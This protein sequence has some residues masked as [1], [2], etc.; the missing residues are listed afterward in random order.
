MQQ[1]GMFINLLIFLFY[2]SNINIVLLSFYIR[3]RLRI[4]IRS[5]VFLPCFAHQINL[6]VGEIFK[7]S[8][9]FKSSI[10]NAMRLATYFRNAN[11]KFFISALKELQKKTYGMYIIPIAPCETKWNSLH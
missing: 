9:E 10:D 7:E 4:S 1:L 3:R 5:V 8:T 2:Y 6:C 11:N